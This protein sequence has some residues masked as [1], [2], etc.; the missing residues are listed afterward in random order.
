[1][2]T[3][4][5]D[6]TPGL[7]WTTLALLALAT[8]LIIAPACAS[9][10]SGKEAKELPPAPGVGRRAPDFTLTDLEGRQIRL[11]DLRGKVVFLNFWATWCPACRE[12]MPEIEAFYRQHKD[13]EVV[14]IGVDLYEPEETVRQFVQRGGYSWNFVIDTTGEVS[15][16]YQVTALPTSF[17]L[18]RDGVIRAIHSGAMTKR[19]METRLSEA[20]R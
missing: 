16:S 18:N 1:M 7:G 9:A 6:R 17:F 19:V 10:A 12:E 11:S 20:G 13:E 3:L 5:R 4:F 2:D 8:T 15:R 14:V